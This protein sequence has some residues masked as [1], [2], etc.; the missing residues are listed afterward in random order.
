MAVIES[1]SS[2]DLLTI[3][4]TTKAARVSVYPRLS[5]YAIASVTG[6]IGATLAANSSVFVARLDPSAGASYKAYITRLTLMFNDIAAV[7]GVN[8][9]LRLAVYRG[10]GAA[11]SGGTALATAA[12]KDTTSANSQMNSG[13]GGDMRIST[14]GA[15][16]VAGIT[17][18]TQELLTAMSLADALITAGTY[19]EK[20]WEFDN[21]QA[22]P[23]VLNQG[24]LIAIRNPVVFP[25]TATWQLGVTMEWFE[26]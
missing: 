23:I 6:T 5:H 25:G 24:E 11:A 8:A 22:S 14:T 20:A 9:G 2:S 16:T 21:P 17:F 13:E 26:G 7:A 19:R 1:G 10:S 3:D 4:T 12:E 15:L 18:E